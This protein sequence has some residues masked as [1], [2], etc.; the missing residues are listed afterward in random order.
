MSNLHPP[1]SNV[2]STRQITIELANICNLHCSY[3]V[4]D[5]DALHHEPAQFFPV[6]LLRRIIRDARDTCGMTDVSFTGGEVTLHPRF[7]ECIEAV[8]AEGLKANFV[9]NGW[10]FD[11]IYPVLLDNRATVRSVAFSLDGATQEAHDYW[12]GKGS[13]VRV[14]RAI[15][16]CHVHGIPFVFKVVIRRDTVPQLEQIALLGA[17]M[18]AAAVLFAHFLP[19]SPEAES[20][21]ALGNIE[22]R[23]AEQEIAV[24]ANIFKIRIGM[25]VGYYDLDPSPPCDTLRGI[26]CNVDYR[27]RLTL[28]CNL[29]GYR[30]AG[31]EPDVIADLTREDFATAYSRFLKLAETQ[32]ERRK[33]ALAAF[34]QNNQEVDWYTGSPCMFCLQS[35]G[36]IPW[37][38]TAQAGARSLPVLTSN[39]VPVNQHRM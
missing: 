20:E 35:F 22:R 36:K 21:S 14:I 7:R 23:Q 18:G 13:F 39:T 33:R 26:N 8:G 27:G 38:P 29:S 12:R 11:R 6:D 34:A 10:H 5:D 4:R 15:T 32:V 28:C 16:R 37:R 25:M 24:L 30:G 31:G 19:T 2:S 9:T 17:R 1:P 3:C